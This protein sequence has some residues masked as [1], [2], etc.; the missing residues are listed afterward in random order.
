LRVYNDLATAY[1]GLSMPTTN[2]EKLKR[3]LNDWVIEPDYSK[4]EHHY[5]VDGERYPSITTVLKC[6]DKPALMPW[7][8]KMV[9][10]KALASFAK[11]VDQAGMVNLPF[12]QVQDILEDAKK[13]YREF[14][15]DAADIGTLVHDSIERFILGDEIDSTD[16]PAGVSEGL[17]AFG[18]WVKG[19]GGVKPVR[20]E[21][22]LASKKHK[23]A[24]KCD[25]IGFIGKSLV[26]ADWKT[27]SGIYDEARFQVAEYLIMIEE[28][29]GKE[30]AGAW[31]VRFDKKTGKFNPRKDAVFVPR[32]ECLRRHRA[33]VGLVR[34]VTNLK[35]LSETVTN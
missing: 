2:R 13:H 15:D 1:D 34:Y 8:A 24:G 16:W 10:K 33:F 7:A 31:I 14:R 32:D 30:L 4:G 20:V 27:S 9:E 29:T 3:P 28:M 23:V 17:A 22:Y 19:A 5:I 11:V 12:G 26:V 21:A 35:E 18:G 25:F 6:L